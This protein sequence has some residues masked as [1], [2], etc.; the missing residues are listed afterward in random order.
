M[1]VDPQEDWRR[2]L[3]RKLFRF[4]V[5][6]R[7]KTQKKEMKM[8]SDIFGFSRDIHFA[9]LETSNILYICPIYED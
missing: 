6:P 7:D 5:N 8:V 4:S 3:F 9:L 2:R 1:L